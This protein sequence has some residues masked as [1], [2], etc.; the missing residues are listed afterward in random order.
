MKENKGVLENEQLGALRRLNGCLLANSIETFHERLRNEGF[1]ADTVRCLFPQLPPMV[2]YAATIKIRGSAPPTAGGIYPD[3]S[4]WWDYVLSVPAP[5]VVVVEDCETHRG[6]GS[7][8]GAVHINILHALGCV[9]AITNGA[10]RDIP[11]AEALRFP[12]FS[13][14]LSVSHAYVHIVDIGGPVKI[15]RLNIQSGDLLHG[16]VHG[17]QSIPLDIAAQIPQVA[18]RIADDDEMLIS[19]CQSPEFSLEKLRAAIARTKHWNT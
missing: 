9:G 12:L 3:R 5:R 1:V 4:D 8:L 17:V 7:L 18:M 16:D 11:A 10:V 19:L 6:L 2:G 13:G 15:G 14:D